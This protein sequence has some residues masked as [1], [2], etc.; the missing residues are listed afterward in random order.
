MT[1]WNYADV[2][3]TVADAQPDLVAVTQGARDMTWG[4]LDRGADGVAR[5]LLDLGVGRQDKVAA[6][7][8]N[9]PEYLQAAFAA[10]KAGL[11]PVNTNYRYGDDELSYLW[12]NADAVAV[13][14]HGVFAERIESILE[15]VP[16]VSGWLW[17]DDGTGPCPEWATPYAEAAASN[18]GRVRAPWGRSGDDLYMLYTGGTTGMP[19]GVMWRQD[20]LFAKLIPSGVRR[21]DEHGGL[22][23][24]RAAI[25]ANPGGATLL[26]ACPLMHG[27]GAFTANTTLAEGGRVV[28]LESR[29]YD[30]AELLDTVEREKVNGL[31]IVGDPFSRPLLAELD[32]HPGHWDLSSLVMVISSGAMWSEPVKQ[33]LLAHHPGMLLVDAFSSSEALGMGMSVSGGGSAAKTATFT[34]GP[35]VKVLTDDGREVQ[36]G[37]DEMG[38]LALGGRNPLGY[39]KDEE[40][41]ARTFKEID[42]V[43]YSVPGDYAKVDADGTIQLLGRGSVCINSGGEK[44][45][46]EEVEEALKTHDAVHD[47]VVVGVPHPTYGEQIVAVIEPVDGAPAPDEAELIGHVKA[48]LAHYKAPRHVRAVGTIGRA[49]N[50]KVDY[51]RHRAESVEELGITAD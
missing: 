6:Y 2:W 30:P 24:V 18:T 34:L 5:F 31:V 1:D 8:Y 22:A 29:H 40:K 12:D 35:D 45:F 49:P 14:F 21:Y 11:V 23:S 44:I 9:S 39:Y 20:D 16:R 43:C 50:G 7:L 28:L 13:V 10:M 27:T 25:E 48:R 46:P 47:A 15:R 26:P 32:E 41:S 51:K 37:S 19:K 4:E 33:R 42:G 17:V 3:E 36:P 38:V